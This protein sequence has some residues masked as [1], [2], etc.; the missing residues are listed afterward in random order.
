MFPPGPIFP[1]RERAF[2]FAALVALV[3]LAGCDPL[4]I[5]ALGVGGSAAVSH[6]MGR[7]T[8]RTFTAPAPRVRTA[9]LAAL[10]RMGL[11]YVGSE[12][13]KDGEV[14][15]ATAT[16]R[17]I[18]IT[19]ESLSPSATRMRVVARNGGIFYD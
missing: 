1:P 4:A 5:T 2:F 10:N 13:S 7:I 18:E 12:K 14:L 3:G 15:R 19:L 6:T 9:S 17:E 16:E 8:Y 11:K